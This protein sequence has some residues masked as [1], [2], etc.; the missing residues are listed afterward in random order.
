MK[1]HS[2]GTTCVAVLTLVSMPAVAA[3]VSGQGTWETTLQAR[4]LDGNPTTIEAYY[5][6]A[7]NITWLANANYGVTNMGWDGAYNWATGLNIDGITGWRLPTT[8]PI[9]GS[10]FN[11]NFTYDGSTDVAYN[12]SAPG[13][14]YAGSTVNEMAHM[15]YVTLGNKGF[16]N[17]S[18]LCPQPDWGLTNNGPFSNIQAAGYWSG[19]QYPN[20]LNAFD[21][22]FS[23]GEQVQD[24]TYSA[25]FAWAVHSGDVGAAVVPVPAA[26]WLFGSGLLGLIGVARR[27]AA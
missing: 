13:T 21:F 3:P 26:V 7:V 15:F 16:C 8:G 17:A 5:D 18:G 10:T 27:K 6:T 25:F 11:T 23:L 19:T 4:D 20:S 9:N 1:T 24:V 22:H 12:I 14:P 2:F